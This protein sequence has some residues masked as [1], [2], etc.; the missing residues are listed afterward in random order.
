M[1]EAELAIRFEDGAKESLDIARKTSDKGE[2]LQYHRDRAVRFYHFAGLMH[3]SLALRHKYEGESNK[4]QNEYS[5]AG[6][7]DMES[8]RILYEDKMNEEAKS[9]LQYALAWYLQ[10]HN[11][12]R[13]AEVSEQYKSIL[14]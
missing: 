14:M 5:L 6:D 2:V 10:G 9:Y 8:V 1:N 11:S 3:Y 12:K 4:A 13:W 7:R